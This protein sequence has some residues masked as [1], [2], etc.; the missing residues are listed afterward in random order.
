MSQLGV[1]SE[2]KL[3]R[4]KKG[5]WSLG[6][7]EKGKGNA[8]QGKK[9]GPERHKHAPERESALG[10]VSQGLLKVEILGEVSREDLNRI[11]ISFPGVVPS[12]GHGV[13]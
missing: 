3:Q 9:R 12:Q 2:N 13:H 5:P 4:Q 8:P 6:E 7:R 1:G 11:L 10:P